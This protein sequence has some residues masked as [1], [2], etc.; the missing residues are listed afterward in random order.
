MQP[1]SHFRWVLCCGVTFCLLAVILGAF[2]AHGLKSLLTEYELAIFETAAQYQMYHGLALLFCGLLGEIAMSLDWPVNIDKLKYAALALLI[3]ILLFSGS[4]Y[5][6]AV[7]G[8]KWLGA[9]TP[10]GGLAFIAAWLLL[11]VGLLSNEK[12]GQQ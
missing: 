2:S 1:F 5:L 8:I 3:G 7:T 6:L 4:L 10:I 11:L 12:T 9:I